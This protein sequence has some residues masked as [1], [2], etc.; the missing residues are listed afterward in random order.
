VVLIAVLPDLLDEVLIVL[1]SEVDIVV[2]LD[3]L[4]SVR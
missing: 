3:G 1:G 2:C 4:R